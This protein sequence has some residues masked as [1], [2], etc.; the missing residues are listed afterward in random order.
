ML[1]YLSI[2]QTMRQHEVDQ[3]GQKF[4]LTYFSADDDNMTTLGGTV[5]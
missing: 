5:W 2:K 3:K 1:G 4:W